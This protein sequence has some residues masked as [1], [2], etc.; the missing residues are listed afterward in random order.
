MNKAFTLVELLVS[1]AVFSVVM[2]L[3]IGG[4]LVMLSINQ[5][6]QALALATNNLAFVFEHMTRSIRT[7]T[8]Y[9]CG[10]TLGLGD[11]PSGGS[12][13]TFLLGNG[14]EVTYSLS[15][16][17]IIRE[18]DGVSSVLTDPSIHIDSLTF[19]VVG[20]EKFSDPGQDV[21]A[22]TVRMV[23]KG[24]VPGLKGV[25]PSFSMETMATMRG[26]DL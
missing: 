5:R 16:N 24:N 3:A 17:S 7:N 4:Y 8:D 15:G 19:Y 14:D 25:S 23:V 13:F 2:T 10:S 26:I 1:I 12:A 21:R 20:T 9:S 22:P 11:C 6:A 18:V